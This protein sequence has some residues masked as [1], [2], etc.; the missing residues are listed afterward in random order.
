[1]QK[2]MLIN[3]AIEPVLVLH[4]HKGIMQYRIMRY[5]ITVFKIRDTHSIRFFCKEL[6]KMF[7]VAHDNLSIYMRVW[8]PK[9]ARPLQRCTLKRGVLNS[10]FKTWWRGPLTSFA[11][12]STGSCHVATF[13]APR[14]NPEPAAESSAGTTAGQS[15][16]DKVGQ[17]RVSRGETSSDSGSPCRQRG[18]G[19]T[20]GRA[21]CT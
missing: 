19:R 2:S 10:T 21:G 3:L 14:V 15:G 4:K 13:Q 7:T 12:A 18:A 9:A 20:R 11:L 1:M 16:T 5:C 6:E 17:G 8:S